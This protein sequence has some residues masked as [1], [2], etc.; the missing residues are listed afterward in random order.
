MGKQIR[1]M[2]KLL[3]TIL[4]KTKVFLKI[5]S[6]EPLPG[7]IISNES[8]DSPSIVKHKM[9]FETPS[10]IVLKLESGNILKC[11]KIRHWTE[12]HKL[13][14]GKYRALEE[15]TSNIRMKTIGL[16]VPVIKYSG[17][18]SNFFSKRKY[19]SFYCMEE[20]PLNFQA[21]YLIFDLLSKEAKTNFIDKVISDV[22]NLKDHSYV[23]SDLS[24]RNFML[25]NDGDYF[26][27]DTQIKA[28][29]NTGQFKS[30]FNIALERFVNDTM[31][32]ISKD[33]KEQILTTLLIK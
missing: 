19:S 30:R 14:F 31:L 16:N 25:N 29:S 4:F 5:N 15:V 9:I 24:L 26:W 28:Y 2:F 32:T 27:I 20:V 17:L 7:Y 6:G 1:K 33:E 11:L 23:Y 10:S 13:L 8:K 22:K 18:F 3:L 12:Y 21:G